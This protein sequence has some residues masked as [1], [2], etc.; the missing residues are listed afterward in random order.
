MRRLGV[1]LALL[2]LCG[3]VALAARVPLRV[4]VVEAEPRDAEVARRLRGQTSDLDVELVSVRAPAPQGDRADVARLAEVEGARVVIW[5][6]H[7]ADVIVVHLV[8]PRTRSEL[9]RDVTS[10]GSGAAAES[11]RA[12]AA[13]LVAR[14]ALRALAR[15]GRIGVGSPPG[16]REP[17][18][19]PDA[20]E[21][22][23]PEP[24]PDGPDIEVR[25]GRP[26]LR[27]T[28]GWQLAFDGE[29]PTGQH[30]LD[31]RL[32]LGRGAW[33]VALGALAGLPG[34]LD[35]DDVAIEVARHGLLVAGGV[36]RRGRRLRLGLGAAL[37]VIAFFRS[38]AALSAEVS[39]TPSQT[40]PVFF[41]SPEAT[42]SL[43]LGGGLWL[44]LTGAADVLL[45]RPDFGY[46]IAGRFA[47]RHRFWPV[48]PRVGVALTL[49]N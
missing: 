38:S 24:S 47:S 2:G 5:F 35:D 30:G 28:V 14:G 45:P 8:D 13:A 36:E 33:H 37:G 16:A 25:G 27:V 42:A 7:A 11:A 22:P 1:A 19:P 40:T 49:K 31:V 29:T 34:E 15:G 9:L 26:A 43:R 3:G 32:G 21:P 10:A 39:A 44:Q 20:P 41:V 6:E 12:E 48:E 4:V 17:E 18:V 23:P 46:Q